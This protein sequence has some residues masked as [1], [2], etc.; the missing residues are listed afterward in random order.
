MKIEHRP[1]APA[2]E[3]GDGAAPNGAAAEYGRRAAPA[4]GEPPGGGEPAVGAPAYR[5]SEGLWWAAAT[6]LARR[7][8]ILGVTVLAAV[9]AAGLTFLIP[10]QYQAETRVMLPQGGSTSMLGLLETVAPGASALLG[11]GGGEYTRYLSIL[12][13]RTVLDR[14]VERFDLERVYETT[15]S[16]DP[17][18]DAIAEL[19]ERM[20][21][22]VALDFDYLALRVLDEQPARAAR[23]ANYLV[24]ELNRENTRLTASSARENLV[25]LERRLNEAEQALDSAKQAMQSFQERHGVVDLERQGEAYFTALGEARAQVARLEVEYGTLRQ[26]FGDDNEQVAFARSALA[27]ARQQAD[28]LTSGRDAMMPVPQAAMAGVGRQYTDLYQ[29]VFTQGKIIEFLRP[30]YEQARFD[31]QREASAVQVLDP[32]IAPVRKAKPQRRVIVAAGTLSALFLACFV[33][34]ALAWWRANAPN[35]A[36]RLR[37]AGSRAAPDPA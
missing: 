31:E 32:A 16:V 12:T 8:V 2:A 19:G 26:Q 18:G 27:T 5:A 37:A 33:V 1:G 9:V 34:L 4:D 35:V 17:R 24:E 15:D 28:R 20:T 23:M 6:L 14:A 36:A 10:P 7:W 22:E 30:L 21:F 3:E 25:F 13:S 29:E 11:K